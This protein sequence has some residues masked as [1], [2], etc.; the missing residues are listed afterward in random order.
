[1][2]CLEHCINC[3][4][5]ISPSEQ[6]RVIEKTNGEIDNVCLDCVGEY[7]ESHFDEVYDYDYE[8][9]DDSE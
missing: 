3:D 5:V 9:L 8:A 1:M 2:Y 7:D 6:Q 4:E